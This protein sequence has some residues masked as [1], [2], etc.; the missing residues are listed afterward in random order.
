MTCCQ[1]WQRIGKLAHQIREVQIE[2]RVLAEVLHVGASQILRKQ[3]VGIGA[4]ARC[5]HAIQ[6]DD[7]VHA[8]H[9]FAEREVPFLKDV[10]GGERLRADHQHQAVARGNGVADFL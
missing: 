8:F 9:C 1:R 5:V 10:E 3:I 7:G 2:C 4:L 6:P